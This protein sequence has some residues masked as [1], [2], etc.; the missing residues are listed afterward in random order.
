MAKTIGKRTLEATSILLAFSM[1]GGGRISLDTAEIGVER[2]PLKEPRS[3]S[4]VLMTEVAAGVTEARSEVAPMAGVGREACKCI[5][6]R[7][8]QG[9]STNVSDEN[10]GQSY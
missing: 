2:S 1:V 9:V 3:A 8:I 7:E 6:M 4:S 5:T 10:R